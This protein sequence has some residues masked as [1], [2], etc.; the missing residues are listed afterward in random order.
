M[1]A[2]PVQNGGSRGGLP[3]F[4]RQVLPY[5][6]EVFVLPVHGDAAGEVKQVARTHALHVG[7]HGRG[8]IVN[9]VT[10]IGKALTYF[11]H[12]REFDKGWIGRMHRKYLRFQMHF[13]TF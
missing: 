5:L 6:A 9:G 2:R 7:T 3:F 1:T 13:M 11:I 10:K 12:N 8:R 4:H